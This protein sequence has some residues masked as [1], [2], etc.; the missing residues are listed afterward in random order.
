[1]AVNLSASASRDANFTAYVAHREPVRF[2]PRGRELKDIAA[3][4]ALVAKLQKM[5]QYEGGR[6]P[7][8]LT[9]SV[10]SGVAAENLVHEPAGASP[11]QLSSY[12]A[13]RARCAFASSSDAPLRYEHTRSYGKH[14]ASPH[15][16]LGSRPP[17]IRQCITAPD[18]SG[19]SRPIS[20]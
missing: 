12:L 4:A 16:L 6:E 3:A 9:H 1:M 15:Y 7:V 11:S 17:E 18:A 14:D 13:L 5:G 10:P 20:A 19:R 8:R 2:A